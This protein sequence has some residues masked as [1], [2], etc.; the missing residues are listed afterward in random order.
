MPA[1]Y[2]AAQRSAKPL[3]DGC[4]AEGQRTEE[5]QIRGVTGRWWS[6]KALLQSGEKPRCVQGWGR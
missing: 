2:G 3:Q 4:S 1:G 5:T 6:N